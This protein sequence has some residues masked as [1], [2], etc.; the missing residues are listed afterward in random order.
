DI[1]FHLTEVTK[2]GYGS[3]FNLN[4]PIFTGTPLKY[5]FFI[6]WISGALF[7]L[8]G[9]LLFSFHLPSMLLAAAGA[10]LTFVIYRK[11]LK[12]DWLAALGVI[13]F[14][15]G[16]G[17]GGA[18]KTYATYPQQ[19]VDWGAPLTSFFLH[20]RAFFL[21]YFLFALAAYC[22]WRYY[23]TRQWRFF[24][25]TAI[26]FGISPMAHYESFVAMGLVIAGV[27]VAALI[28]KNFLF[29]RQALLLLTCG[30]LIA[31]P[32]IF[33]LLS[34]K[35][36]VFSGAS[37]FIHF[38]LGWM[39]QPSSGSVQFSPTAN[40]LQKLW[41][42]LGFLWIN[43]GIVLIAAM[44]T[45]AWAVKN[46][47]TA[48]MAIRLLALAWVFF[49]IVQIIQFQPWDFDNNKL[50][51]YWQFFAVPPILLMLN[52]AKKPLN[53][54]F[55]MLFLVL[56]TVSGIKDAA[57]RLAV[58]VNQM[59]VIFTSRDQN[60]A[61]FIR[62]HV[63][64]NDLII[65]SDTFLNPAASLAGMPALVGYP[66]WLW[67]HGINYNQRKQAL[68]D[69]YRN[70]LES[71]LPETYHASYVL[72]DQTA[73]SEWGA[74]ESSFDKAFQKVYDDGTHTLYQ[75]EYGE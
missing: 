71:T 67:S 46:K 17:F 48:K 21:G 29:F 38:R 30:L 62:Q 39:S 51:V 65:T 25:P 16:A 7:K 50:L 11:F 60:L 68:A 54:V 32:Q 27:A 22:L 57:A 75:I 73:K 59:P 24:F 18:I 47:T 2:F 4:E 58:P 69:F 72:L 41:T 55:I 36:D 63:S 15:L 10:V 43:F 52:T 28:K 23:E 8:T 6:N 53:I 14:M 40:A 20:Q 42:Y 49:F 19:N 26:A 31:S 5:S 35:T 1:P 13:V 56:A 74:N 70:P 3:L 66:G 34:G 33:Y 64:Q 45:S 12:H 61:R 37:A 9:N 44:I